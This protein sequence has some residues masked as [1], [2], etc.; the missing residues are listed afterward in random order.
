MPDSDTPPLWMTQPEALAVFRAAGTPISES[1]LRRWANREFIRTSRTPGNQRRYWRE[2][3]VR[4]AVEGI[5]EPQ[6][7]GATA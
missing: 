7:A 3:V 1:T 6:P 5:S 2:D 4:I